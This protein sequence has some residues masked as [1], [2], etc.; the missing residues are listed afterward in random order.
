MKLFSIAFSQP[1]STR[2]WKRT[3]T[4]MLKD[5]GII[6]LTCTFSLW[7]TC[8][9]GLCVHHSVG[10]NGRFQKFVTELL[11]AIS[12][13]VKM[14]DKMYYEKSISQSMVDLRLYD[15]QTVMTTFD[16]LGA[17]RAAS[18]GNPVSQFLELRITE[19]PI[20]CAGTLLPSFRLLMFNSLSSYPHLFPHRNNLCPH[21]PLR[22]CPTK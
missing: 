4:S 9:R 6:N 17:I 16:A 1:R 7:L 5:S 3:R 21:P 12:K 10:H 2:I 8:Y 18:S 22:C 11:S 15:Y 19:D 13:A 20:T 14:Y